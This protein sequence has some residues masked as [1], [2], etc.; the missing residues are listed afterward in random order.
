ML[1][2]DQSH[3]VF[4]FKSNIVLGLNYFFPE[5]ESIWDLCQWILEIM[6]YYILN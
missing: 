5:T 2:E 4:L 1:T 3:I 6:I